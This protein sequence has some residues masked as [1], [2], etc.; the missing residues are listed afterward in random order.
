[1]KKL[2]FIV[3]VAALALL[4]FAAA[5]LAGAVK[6]P[7]YR[8]H[9]LPNGL[10]VFVMETREV[11][12]VTVSLVVPAGSAMDDPGAEGIANLAGRL[13][14]KGAGGM[15]AE[16][17]AESIEAI[18]GSIRCRTGRDYTGAYA[19]F[20][21]KDLDRAV[22]MLAKV[23][24]AP[25][26]PEEELAREKAL[27][28]AEIAGTKDNP[29]A[30]A[31]REFVR[32]LAG[33]H[34]YAHPVEG[35]EESV[36]ALTRDRVLAFYDAAYVPRGSVLAVVGDVDAKK[37]LDLVKARF[38]G[39]KGE[40]GARAIPALAPKTFPG[41][42]VLVVDKADA[43]QSQIR[44]GNVTVPRGTSEEFPLVVSN[45]VLGGG[46]TSRLM[47][48]IRVNRGLSYGARSANTNFRHGGLFGVYTY[49][50]NV[51]LRECIDVAL[52]QVERM[53]TEK[54]SDAEL[55]SAKKYITGLFPFDVETNA[56]LANWLVDLTFYGIPV[57]YV[58]EYGSK[59]D[60]VTADDCLAAARN[61]YWRDDNLM[62][63]MTK[64]DETKAQLEGLG[65]IDVVNIADVK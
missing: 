30:F 1:M 15:T 56:D 39:W 13:L 50:K 53:R 35:S 60:A 17:I 52:E 62:F 27:V 18:G 59:I 44:F 65:K 63:L 45:T 5:A 24:L 48:E 55:A 46:F 9:E 19:N 34:P 49:T 7:P 3:C 40:A 16:Q 12:L 64:Y 47:D 32:A 22:D 2:P 31:S 23:V 8:E 38:G 58:E 33:D 41:R 11:P 42:R 25:S 4:V 57:S 61:R 43:T 28:A 29:M 54:L 26:F 10:R 6:L 14:L 51:S 37:A 21:A 36:N 20:M